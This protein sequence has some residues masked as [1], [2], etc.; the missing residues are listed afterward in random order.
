MY[1]MKHNVSLLLMIL[2]LWPLTLYGQMNLNDCM[3]Y[4]R[5]HAM[6]NQR[7]TIS[8]KLAQENRRSAYYNYLPSISAG[9]SGQISFGRSI[10]PETNAYDTRSTANNG[11]SLSLSLP[12]FTGLANFNNVRMCKAIERMQRDRLKQ[13]QDKVSLLV[14]QAFYSCIY[15]QE[16]VKQL[17]LQLDASALSLRQG[18][19]RL[20]MGAC[21]RADVAQLDANVAAAEYSIIEHQNLYDQA[22]IDL[23]A[24]M[25]WPIDSLL[26]I[27]EPNVEEIV[28]E[29]LLPDRDLLLVQALASLPEVHAAQSALKSSRYSFKSTLSGFMPSLSFGAGY[30]TSYFVDLKHRDN[31]VSFRDQLNLNSG[32]YLSLSLSIPIFT[33]LSNVQNYRRGKLNYRSSKIDYEE[34]IY[35]VEVEVTQA[36][37]D[38]KGAHKEFV[39]ASRRLEAVELAHQA[40][41]RKFEQGILSPLDLQTSVT[42]LAQARATATGKKIQWIIKQRQVKYYSGEPFIQ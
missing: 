3:L 27:D 9:V 40:N 32:E 24:V 29:F 7:Q 18:K 37:M 11:Y 20:E 17:Q 36:L 41:V 2:V 39:S 21:S 10:D 28:S 42:Q 4:A 35:N 6:D 5:D 23:K 31:Y 33:R 38:L 14:M 26:T 22:L 13:T 15:Y 34:V 8:Y 1:V 19:V 30:S 12:I 25:N 16:I